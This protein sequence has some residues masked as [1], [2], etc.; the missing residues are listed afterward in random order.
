MVN[1]LL[2][3]FFQNKCDGTSL[4]HCIIAQKRTGEVMNDV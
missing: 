2:S 3:G 4:V 1:D